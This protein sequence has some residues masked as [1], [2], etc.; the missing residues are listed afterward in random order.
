[1][2]KLKYWVNGSSIVEVIT[3]SLIFMIVFTISI[4]AIANSLKLKVPCRNFIE[5]D[6]YSRELL[7]MYLEDCHPCGEYI[8]E[9]DSGKAKVLIAPYREC[10]QIYKLDI[11]IVDDKGKRM[12]KQTHLVCYEQKNVA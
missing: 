12:L 3:A 6:K 2:A 4:A 9:I 10:L 11:V 5:L 1:M 8:H 7:K